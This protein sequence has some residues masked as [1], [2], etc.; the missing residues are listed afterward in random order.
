MKGTKAGKLTYEARVFVVAQLATFASP[1]EI[2]RAVRTLYGIEV[3]RQAI[4]RY[5][6]SN[7]YG[8]RAA[9]RWKKVHQ[10][11]RRRFLTSVADVPVAH[12]VYRL[13]C[14]N[15]MFDEA[16]EKNDLKMAA[17]LLE[18]AGREVGDRRVNRRD[19]SISA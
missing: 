16:L 2:A 11:T 8:P 12:R 10:E 3:S 15:A 19:T 13:K 1:Q 6:P 17:R 7:P 18:Q 9:G 4:S 5:D 14:L